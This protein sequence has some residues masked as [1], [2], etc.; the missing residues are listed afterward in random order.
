MSTGKMHSDEVNT[1]ISLVLQLL[2][3]QSP[4]QEGGLSDLAVMDNELLTEQSIFGNEVSFAA[5]EVCD[6]IQH[7]RLMGRFG[8]MQEGLFEER[9][10]SDDKLCEPVKG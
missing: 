2:T 3:A 4:Q 6:G 8:E 7:N 5:C 1:N 10:Q 9:D